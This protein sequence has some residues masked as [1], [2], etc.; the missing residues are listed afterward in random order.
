M[1]GEAASNAK[2]GGI[3]FS[4]RP[5]PSPYFAIDFGIDFVGGRDFNGDPRRESSFFVNPVVF[6]NPRDKVQLYIFGGLGVA[7][8]RVEQAGID[9]RYRYIGADAGA[10]VEFRYWRRFA[11]SADV[12]AFVR[13]RVDVAGAA[14]EYFDRA[15]GRYTDSSA[16]AL[17]RF[18]G[19]YYW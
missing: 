3:G 10:G 19:T 1:G 16:G 6:L 14:P 2:M 9:K 8:A 15:T 4:L 11:L 5:R 12:L 13:D 17:F 18:G 7:T